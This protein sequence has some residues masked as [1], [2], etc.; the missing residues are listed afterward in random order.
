MSTFIYLSCM[1]FWLS[2]YGYLW[3]NSE[4]AK[5]RGKKPKGC[6]VNIEFLVSR[7][8]HLV[9]VLSLS[10]TFFNNHFLST[11]THAPL[12]C[13][14]SFIFKFFLIFICLCIFKYAFTRETTLL[15]RSRRV[16]AR[17]PKFD[18]YSLPVVFYLNFWHLSTLCIFVVALPS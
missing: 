12:F 9:E 8:A 7:H 4:Q 1:K 18:F 13:D 5:Q 3:S 11:N 16:G 17:D 10:W 2:L 6:G 14:T 15:E